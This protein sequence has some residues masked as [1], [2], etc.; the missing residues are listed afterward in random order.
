MFIR[1]KTYTF[2][3]VNGLLVFC[4]LCCR[5][6]T[7]SA[8]MIK[9]TND[10]DSMVD[11]QLKSNL[12][13]YEA[14]LSYQ[15]GFLAAGSDGRIDWISESG[16]VEQTT[17]PQSASINALLSVGNKVLAAGNKGVLLFSS[18]NG[19]FKLLESGTN[20]TI[21][22]LTYF[23]KNIIAGADQ[24][25]V[26]VG[27]LGEPL[28][29]CQLALKGNV[30]SVSSNESVCFGVTDQGEI[31][32]TTDGLNWT[33]FDYNDFYFGYYKPSYFTSVLVTDKQIAVA[34]I[35]EDGMPVLLFSAQGNVWTDRALAYIDDEGISIF[36]KDIPLTIYYDVIE[37]QFVLA[38][39]NGTLQFV[40]A[41]SH[42]N[43]VVHYST[44]ALTGIASNEHTWM[45]VGTS[46]FIK[47]IP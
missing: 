47:A 30:V 27:S 24:G 19:A 34:G 7:V 15:R 29:P 31:I 37:D 18:D 8:T 5:A 17:K 10:A 6:A 16:I 35:K 38:C 12:S 33:I 42:C 22:A 4:S 28:S 1:C 13:G 23:K 21:N 39:T 36:S 46:Y 25:L 2:L 40:P 20:Q 32:H 41:C 9:M 3:L 26:L 11:Y 44:E 14:I 45:I 43:K